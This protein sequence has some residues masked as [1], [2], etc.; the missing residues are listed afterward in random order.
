MYSRII[1]DLFQKTSAEGERSGYLRCSLHRG[2][3]VSLKW[4]RNGS[5][6]VPI[7]RRCF[8]ARDL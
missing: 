3:L 4:P 2:S 5:I 6:G 8:Y 1:R 7:G